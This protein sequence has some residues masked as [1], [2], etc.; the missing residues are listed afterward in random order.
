[1]SPKKKKK[2]AADA[3]FLSSNSK[4][5][6][7]EDKIVQLRSL[8]KEIK[9]LERME[10][11]QLGRQED[12]EDASEMSR[13]GIHKIIVTFFFSRRSAIFDAYRRHDSSRCLLRRFLRP[14]YAGTPINSIFRTFRTFVSAKG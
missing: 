5:A 3:V 1:L 6:F 13:D 4:T 2:K 9:R 14:E 10:Y 7:H 11:A 8:R 12:E